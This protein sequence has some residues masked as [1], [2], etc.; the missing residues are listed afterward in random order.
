[1]NEVQ[2]KAL[3]LL[4]G[5]ID[6]LSS[7]DEIEEIYKCIDNL[8]EN[9]NGGLENYRIIAEC[10]AKVK[11]YKKAQEEFEKI[12]NTKNKKDIKKYIQYS[13]NR[14]IMPIIR[15]SK[16]AK[17]ISNIKYVSKEIAERMFIKNE[18]TACEICNSTKAPLYA[19]SAF[20]SDSSKICC[21]NYEKKFCIDCL[22]S[23]AAAKF[24]NISFNNSLINSFS[25][26]DNEK[27]EDIIYKT[28]SCSSEFDLNEDIWPIC[29][30]DFCKYIMLDEYNNAYFKCLTCGKTIKWKY[31][32]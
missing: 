19:G 9:I 12:Y 13:K 1:M 2:E 31:F 27:K 20:K 7:D 26:V 24:Y 5:T 8:Y 3:K 28:P 11:N 6:R 32:D 22:L 21:A 4:T 23:G 14:E 25:A 30:G 17:L 16:R 29:C 10:Y 18:G 15:P